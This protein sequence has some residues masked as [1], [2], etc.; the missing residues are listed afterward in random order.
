MQAEKLKRYER[1]LSNIIGKKK[2]KKKAFKSVALACSPSH[3]HFGPFHNDQ[4]G[5]FKV[6]RYTNFC[7][8]HL[9]RHYFSQALHTS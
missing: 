7:N 5:N 8:A 2:K 6:N 1:P 3:F 4:L 9:F